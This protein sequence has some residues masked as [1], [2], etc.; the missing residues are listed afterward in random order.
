MIVISGQVR[1]DLIADYEKVRQLG[2][3]E[4]NIDAM[5]RPITKYFATGMDPTRIRWEL[6]EAA[7]IARAGRPGPGS[8]TPPLDVQGAT[9]DESTLR[10]WDETDGNAAAARA[11]S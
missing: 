11:D 8:I 3:Q 5:A 1:R 4:I 10:R 2:P 9:V 7:A 6:E